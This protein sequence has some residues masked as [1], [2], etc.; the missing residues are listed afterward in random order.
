VKAG[1][2]NDW[3]AVITNVGVVVGIVFVVYEI[4]QN[5]E[6]LDREYRMHW[7]EVYASGMDAL[8][9]HALVRIE[10]KEVAD[11]W[12][13]GCQ[14]QDLTPVDQHR[15]EELLSMRVMIWRMQFDQWSNV[16]GTPPDWMINVIMKE[17]FR[18]CPKSDGFLFAWM[19]RDP[20]VALFQRIRELKPEW[21][22]AP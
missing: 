22:G 12:L 21:L 19:E 5:S 1:E 8:L 9:G 10:S 18:R 11:L 13:R 17:H 3:L 4:R 2:I 15:F 16:D 6:A 20:S 7:S 14:G